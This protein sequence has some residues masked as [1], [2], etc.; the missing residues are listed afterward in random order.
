MPSLPDRS[1]LFFCHVL[2]E[3]STVY[4]YTDK[5]IHVHFSLLDRSLALSKG[6]YVHMYIYVCVCIYIYVCVCVYVYVCICIYIYMY[7][8][9]YI[10]IYIYVYI[11]VYTH[12]HTHTH[13]HSHTHIHT[14]THTH[15]HTNDFTRKML[16]TC[17][18][19]KRN[20]SGK[21]KLSCILTQPPRMVS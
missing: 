1:T 3:A 14:H 17:E 11:Y 9:I 16:C 15:T 13:T 12:T 8:Y 7:I 21:Y 6:V 18:V 19:G 10:Y 5:C 4:I 2:L 20:D